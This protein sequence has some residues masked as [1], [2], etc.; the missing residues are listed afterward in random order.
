M[1][2]ILGIRRLDSG[3]LHIGKRITVFHDNPKSGTGFTIRIR[4]EK[5]GWICVRPPI[6]NP[7][8]RCYLYVSPNA[9]PW[10]ATYVVGPGISKDDKEY[11]PIRRM[12]LGHNFDAV[13][14]T[15]YR[16][17]CAINGIVPEE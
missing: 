10:A 7:W 2:N 11:A 5:F 8:S 9:T 1:R 4:T 3:I 14:R 6:M 15:V 17:L 16:K 13:D 12:V